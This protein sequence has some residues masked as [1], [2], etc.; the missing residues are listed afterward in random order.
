MQDPAVA[1]ARTK[2]DNASSDDERRQAMREYYRLLFSKMR[3]LDS[4]LGDRIER[5]EGAAFRRLDRS[6]GGAATEE[7]EQQ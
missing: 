5:M 1:D 7:P 4:S 6:G 3:K 2:A